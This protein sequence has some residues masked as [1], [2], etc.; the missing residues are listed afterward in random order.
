MFALQGCICLIKNTVRTEGSVNIYLHV[1]A[2]GSQTSI[3]FRYVVPSN[4]PTAINWPF[5]TAKPTQSKSES[6]FVGHFF[7]KRPR[8]DQRITYPAPS[9]RH[10][11][12]RGP[13]IGSGIVTLSAAQFCGIVSA[14]HR[15]NHVLVHGTAQ[16]FPT[17]P[18]GCHRMPAV[19]LRVI[20]LH[21]RTKQ[22]LIN[23]LH[24]LQNT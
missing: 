20:A 11:D 18:H 5:T 17:S 22:L 1:F 14:A 6:L 4:P 16:V 24:F 8:R 23:I 10:G 7:Y 2:S 9:G 21:C 12:H 19:L 3:V 15:V 13:L